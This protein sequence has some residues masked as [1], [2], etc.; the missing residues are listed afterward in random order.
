[1][2]AMNARLPTTQPQ[3]F[4][5]DA[6]QSLGR[7]A[8]E[9]PGATAVFRRQKL[10]FCCGGQIS[11]HQAA[12]D[13]GLD[14]QALLTELGA[15]QR[16]DQPVLPG[17]PAGLIDHI[18]ERY[19][20]VHRAQLPELIRMARRVEAV[21]RENPQVPTGLAEL[22]ETMEQELLQHMAKEE[23]I[24]FPALKSGTKPFVAQPIAMMRSEHVDHG[25]ML[26]R[27]AELSNGANPP[28]GAC[29]TWRAL[30]AGIAQL[31]DDLVSHIH[32]ENTVLFAQFDK[33]VVAQS[34]CCGSCG[35]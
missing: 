30:Y 20:A 26:E 12:A 18:L 31:S 24:L 19:H 22:L 7:I 25:V 29:N 28:A 35:G 14:L 8:V 2:D 3:G 32:L 21:H 10:D 16:A 11:L 23:Q 15:L 9:L 13:K 27:L 5:L 1:M 6:E 33:P 4:V 17:D 34:P